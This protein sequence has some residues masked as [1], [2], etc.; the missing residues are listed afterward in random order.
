M[1]FSGCTELHKERNF[2]VK[3]TMKNYPGR[4]IGPFK[5]PFGVAGI[6]PRKLKSGTCPRPPP[7]PEITLFYGDAEER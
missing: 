1:Y 6:T 7:A 2:A 5:R 4:W 3:A